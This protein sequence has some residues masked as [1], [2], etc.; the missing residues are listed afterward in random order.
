M[1]VDRKRQA[2]T[3]RRLK[4]ERRRRGPLGALMFW[5]AVA[6]VPLLI[7]A[8]YANHYVF[9]RS[10]TDVTVAE[11]RSYPANGDTRYTVRDKNGKL[12]YVEGF[13]AGREFHRLR[14]GQRYRCKTRGTDK[15]LPFWFDLHA[16]ITSCDP[17]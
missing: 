9:S 7:A 13:R 15:E 5:G 3:K 2:C 11:T 14:E 10:E 4:R 1:P 12:Y 8:F 17:V 16:K 6:I